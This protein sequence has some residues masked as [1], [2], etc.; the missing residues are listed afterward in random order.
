VFK[1]RRHVGSMRFLAPTLQFFLLKGLRRGSVLCLRHPGMVTPNL[2]GVKPLGFAFGR[3][4]TPA[5]W[6]IGISADR[7]RG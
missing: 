5:H 7:L 4:G 6:S 1:V 3:A 2:A